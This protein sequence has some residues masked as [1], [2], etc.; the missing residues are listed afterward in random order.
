MGPGLYVGILAFNLTMTLWIGEAAL[1]LAGAFIYLPFLTWLVVK[2][3]PG[4]P[5][6]GPRI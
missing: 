2:I 1:F 6:T 3:W 4:P 5:E